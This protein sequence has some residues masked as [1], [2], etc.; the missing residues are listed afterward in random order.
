[1]LAGA[2]RAFC[3]GA[4]LTAFSEPHEVH[5][6]LRRV[7]AVFD[8]V[9]QLTKPVIAAVRGIAVGGGLELVLCA[10]LVVATGSAR[11]GDAHANYGLLPGAGGSVRLPRRIGPARAK[12]L[13]FTGAVLPAAAFADTDLI[14]ILTDDDRLDQEIDALTDAIAAKSPVG[15]AAMKQL[16]GQGLEIGIAEA[17][18]RE[19]DRLIAHAHTP[20]FTEG[21]RAF[22]EKRPPVF[23]G[24]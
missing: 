4:D 9:E 1:V 14:T 23:T 17:L 6:F 5:D 19:Q 10:D 15:L 24:N 22:I 7:G 18:C 2:G 16:V 12:H 3:A 21:I 13:M 8:R 20:D 11:F